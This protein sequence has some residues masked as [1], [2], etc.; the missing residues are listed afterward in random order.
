LPEQFGS[1]QSAT[2]KAKLKLKHTV[3]IKKSEPGMKKS[4]Q[5]AFFRLTRKYI[6]FLLIQEWSSHE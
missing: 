3:V 1:A 2:K 5:S 6:K 4:L